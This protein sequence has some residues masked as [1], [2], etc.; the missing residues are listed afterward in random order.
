MRAIIPKLITKMNFDALSFL[1][2]LA[3]MKTNMFI[4]SCTNVSS[5]FRLY[6]TAIKTDTC[7]IHFNI[8]IC[9][10]NAAVIGHNCAA[11]HLSGSFSEPSGIFLKK[12]SGLLRSPTPKCV[13]YFASWWCICLYEPR[14]F[15]LFLS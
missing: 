5:C 14:V 13:L 8:S 15:C 10:P 6:R 7:T 3:P 1:S 2:L 12:A 11:F 4:K 9:A